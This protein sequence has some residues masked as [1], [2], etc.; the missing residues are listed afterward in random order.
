MTGAKI[1]PSMAE[2][3]RIMVVDDEP[4]VLESFKMILKI[5]DYDVATFPDGPSALAQLEKRKVPLNFFHY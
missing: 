5:K 3:V 2:N 1:T 4:S